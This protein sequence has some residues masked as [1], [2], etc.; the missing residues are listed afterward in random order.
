VDYKS[1]VNL[2]QTDFA[3]K[4]DLARREPVMQQWWESQDIYGELRRIARGRPRFVLHDGPPYANGPIHIGHAA[5]KILKDFIVKSRSLDGCDSPYI[6]GWDCHGLPI[7]LQVEKKL[8]RVGQKLDARAFRAACR[9]YA[10]EQVELQRTAFKRLGVMGDWD[11]PYLTMAP[12]YEAN[13][14]RALGKV[15]ANGHIYIGA[16][17]VY[18]CLDCRSALAEAEVE[19]EDKT[20]PAIDVAFA[21]AD[22][23]ELA[24]RIGTAVDAALPPAV[25]I[26]T[27]TP[28]TL[29]A[30]EAVALRDEYEYVLLDF[31]QNGTRR[32]IVVAKGLAQDCLARY[33]ATAVRELATFTGRA[34]EGLKLRHPF[35]DR[36]VPV[37]LGDHVT[38]EA[39]TGA[40]HTAPAH[41]QDDYIVGKRYGLPVVNPVLGDG[42]FQA[43]V[44]L[45]GGMKL[46]D[47]SKLIIET[48]QASGNLLHHAPVRHSYPHCWRHKTPV[49][50][51]ATPQWFISMEQKG[52]RANTLRDIP[53]VQWIPG[54]G[55]Q[56]IAGM[57][58]TRP[59]WCI[60][61]QRTWGVPIPLFVHEG[62]NA[63]HPR[64]P[65]LIEA[66]ATRVEKGGIDAW[67]DLDAAELLGSDAADYRKV[68]DVMDVWAD[69]G[70][71]FE[72]VGKERPEIAAPVEMYL[73]GSDQHRGWFHSSLLMSEAMY[74]R[75]PYKSVLTY[76]F[77]VDEKGRKMSK[78]LGN[79]VAPDKVMSNL[80]A[81]V[82]R[83][84][85]AATDYTSEM[86][87]SDE[88]L[89]RMSDSYRRMRNTVRFLLGNLH[90]FDPAL[91]VVPTDKLLD[92][93]AW[94]VARA[95]ALQEE[96]VT[97]YRDY[98]FHVIYQRVHNFCVNDLGGLY[99]DVL[100][101]RMYTTPSEGHARR[102]GQTAMFHILQAMVRWLAPILSFT[103]EEIWQALPGR[104]HAAKSVLLTTWYEFPTLPAPGAD[105]DALIS[106]RQAVQRELEKLREAGTIGAPLEAQLDVYCLPAEVRKLAALGAE[107]RFLTITSIAKVHEVN[108]APKDAVV[109]ETGSAII[110]GVWLK[111]SRAGGSKCVR[112]WHWTDD[113][114]VDSHHP[115][116]C[117]RCAGNVSGKPEVRRHV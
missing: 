20:S 39:G 38:L 45:V 96:V 41:G 57:I 30:N 53:K 111:V 59:D 107:L 51:R 56:R 81:D 86:S 105:W 80:G 77:T 24:K 69:S 43:D 115:E 79:V 75:A 95:A 40:V 84:W 27:T 5:N 92:F 63:L 29:P 2:P 71:S 49:I 103:A 108:A 10:M 48:L 52:L 61:R 60:S 98:Q 93:D 23:A 1:T 3:M 33:G 13:Q 88:I 21:V 7:E 8:G 114:G 15:I 117:G 42:R 112:C 78:S 12:Q 6:P 44:P 83:L 106:L 67:F 68:T 73:E 4:A 104:D 110:P 17:P 55:Q 36:L 72:C 109:A 85:V 102:S 90:G 94:V 50:F 100:K 31:D 89:K 19:Y 97:A 37:I 9:A 32:R 11:R 76:G 28:W 66:V 99:L 82:L 116:L 18:W 22:V 113:V 14:I 34:L 26:W 64:T 58:E 101:D 74:G 54:W 65:E 91:H 35:Q 47:A 87:C 70:V 16:K 25:V 46:D 62:T